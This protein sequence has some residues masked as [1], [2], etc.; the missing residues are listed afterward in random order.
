[1]KDVEVLALEEPLGSAVSYVDCLVR[2]R[3]EGIEKRRGG[4][5]RSHYLREID[6]SIQS[7]FVPDESCLT[8]LLVICLSQRKNLEDCTCRVEAAQKLATPEQLSE[9]PY[10]TRCACF[11]WWLKIAL[12]VQGELIPLARYVNEHPRELRETP[13]S[14]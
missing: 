12:F 9:M 7:R 5:T 4:R 10:S 8:P 14:S 11:A 2:S 1:M 13:L 3:D 6:I